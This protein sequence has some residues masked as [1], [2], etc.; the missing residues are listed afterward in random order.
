MF[1]SDFLFSAALHAAIILATFLT[2]PFTIQDHDYGEVIRVSLASSDELPLIRPD[3]PVVETPAAIEDDAG[4]DLAISDPTTAKA[5]EIKPKD[6][7][8]PKE[9]EKPKTKPQQKPADDAKPGTSQEAEG[10][11]EVAGTGAGTPFA[12]A[13][14]DN[15]SFN[16]PAWFG[17][18]FRKLAQNFRNPVVYDGTLYCTMYFQVIKSGR[19]IDTKVVEPSEI[20]AFNEACE[21]AIERAAPFPPLP[22]EF[23]EEIIGITITFTNH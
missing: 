23:R 13:R 12:G 6:K 10:D 22:R 21:L 14:T 20:P 7:P 5:V 15:A 11:K 1:K 16:Y 19:V 2:A 9:P 4:E 17:L 18:A 3:L 8:K